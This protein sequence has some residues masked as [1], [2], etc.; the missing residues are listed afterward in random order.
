MPDPSLAAK[1]QLYFAVALTPFVG[2]S[3]GDVGQVS[4]GLAASVTV[5]VK[6]HD[7]VAPI[8]SFTVHVIDVAPTLYAIPDA[9]VQDEDAI[10][11]VPAD[12]VGPA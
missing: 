3:D 5:I 8:V 2:V 7:E 6:V 12:I 1:L 9:L 4:V 10:G 11:L